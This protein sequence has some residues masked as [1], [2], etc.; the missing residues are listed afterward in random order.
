MKL[1]LKIPQKSKPIATSQ[2]KA[3]DEK[4]SG[5]LGTMEQL[6]DKQYLE[7]L[8]KEALATNTQARYYDML[9]TQISSL[10]DKVVK[11]DI[12]RTEVPDSNKHLD[13][14]RIAINNAVN[15]LSQAQ[16]YARDHIDK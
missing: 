2:S 16:Q 8:H 11:M 10:A 5:S 1:K 7:Q 15:E 6:A 14:L 4:E 9:E 12:T 13:K 3:A